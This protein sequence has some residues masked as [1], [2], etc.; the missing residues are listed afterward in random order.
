VENF[1]ERLRE[2]LE[3]LGLKVA[4]AARATG[5]PSGQGLRD[6]V[7]GRKR[8]TAELLA[9]LI[10]LGVNERYVLTGLR[11]GAQG[12]ADTG[13]RYTPRDP[14]CDQIQRLPARER[15]ALQVLL[16]SILG[17]EAGD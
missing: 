11:D 2:E 13:S 9:R 14:L 12:V 1:H 5:D 17:P 6:V 10:P 16:A 3:R 8:L 15:E 4:E 7:N